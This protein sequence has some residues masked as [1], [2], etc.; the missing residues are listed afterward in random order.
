MSEFNKLH[1]HLRECFDSDSFISAT[2]DGV[3]FNMYEWAFAL[4]VDAK[5][6]HD[7]LTEENKRLLAALSESQKIIS[8]GKKHV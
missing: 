1:E 4:S 7:R 2:E 6:E 8:E 3:E 5:R